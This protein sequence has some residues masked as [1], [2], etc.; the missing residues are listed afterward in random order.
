MSFP[1]SAQ[2][3]PAGADADG[4]LGYGYHGDFINGWEPDFLS[5]AI[6]TCTSTS[7]NVH[8]CPLFTLQS[9][10]EQNKCKTDVPD[11]IKDEDCEKKQQGLPG[12]GV[13]RCPISG[14]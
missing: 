5:K 11:A 4:T 7:G 10:E 8:D 13:F 9:Q 12:K 3:I 14:R 1:W 2:P 6:K